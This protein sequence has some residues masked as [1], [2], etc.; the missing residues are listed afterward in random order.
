MTCHLAD[1]LQQCGQSLLAYRNSKIRLR[2]NNALLSRRLA[3]HLIRAL[4]RL[5]HN[6][7]PTLLISYGIYNISAMTHS[8]RLAPPQDIRKPHPSIRGSETLGIIPDLGY[9]AAWQLAGFTCSSDHKQ[10]TYS[11]GLCELISLADELLNSVIDRL[12][13]VGEKDLQTSS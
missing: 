6:V 3:L 9:V 7:N 4:R 1:Q 12:P 2:K 8:P 11:H 10:R 5:R 13:L